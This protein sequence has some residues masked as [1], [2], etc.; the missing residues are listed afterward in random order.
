[1]ASRA[2]IPVRAYALCIVAGMIV[3]VWLTGPALAWR[4]AAPTTTSGTSPVWAIV[5]GLIGGRLYHVVSDPE[6]YFENGEHPIDAFKIWD[7]GLG[8][9]GA[10]ALGGVGA[11]IGCRR[12]GIRLAAFAD[13]A[14]PGHRVRPG[15]R[16]LG[17]LVQQRALRRPDQPAVAAADPR[18][19]TSSPGT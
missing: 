8:I 9:W 16:P 10:I 5:F 18:R 12:K 1:M 11:W 13:A 2:S 15:H 7:G 17:Q 19:S 6:L 14:A 3:A 4:A